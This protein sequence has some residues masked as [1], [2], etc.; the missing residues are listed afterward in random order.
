VLLCRRARCDLALITRT[1]Q[2]CT[3]LLRPSTDRRPIP[4]NNTPLTKMAER[5]SVYFHLEMGL[6]WRPRTSDGPDPGSQSRQLTYMSKSARQRA[7]QFPRQLPP[8]TTNYLTDSQYQHHPSN[9][10]HQS[11]YQLS[12]QSQSQCGATLFGH[13]PRIA[14]PAPAGPPPTQLQHHPTQAP[15]QGR[16]VRSRG[17]S[18]HDRGRSAPPPLSDNSWDDTPEPMA[19][20]AL[21]K[22]K[23]LSTRP[24]IWKDLPPLPGEFRLGHDNMP[25]SPT[26]EYSQDPVVVSP[27]SAAVRYSQRP[28][29]NQMTD[30]NDKVHTKEMQSLATAMMTVDNG[31]ED[32]WWYQGPRLV[33]IAGDLMPSAALAERYSPAGCASRGEVVSAQAADSPAGTMADLVSPMSDCSRSDGSSFILRRSL[34]TCSEELHMCG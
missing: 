33:N 4:R 1:L 20:T 9:Q 14:Q 5:P 19:A 27:D 23:P 15:Q 29:T 25:W 17:R 2:K 30:E 6:Q 3:A 12:Q 34:T 24:Q 26:E 10:L 21:P 13:Q 32:Q 8:P 22:R 11:T 18:S 31:F 7:H 16:V 28:S